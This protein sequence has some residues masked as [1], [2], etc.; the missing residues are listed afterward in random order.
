MRS[1]ST[2]RQAEYC[3]QC[4]WLPRSLPLILRAAPH[5]RHN[6]PPHKPP[7]G[8]NIKHLVYLFIYFGCTQFSF[9]GGS[10][11]KNLPAD[12]ENVGSIPWLGRSPGGGNGNPLQYSCQGNHMDCGA[13]WATVHGVTKTWI[14]LS[15]YTHVCAQSQLWHMNYQ[16]QHIRSSSL[17]RDQTQ[18]L[19][20]GSTESQPGD[21]QGNPTYA[22]ILII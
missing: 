1:A 4:T 7:S 22:I 18:A 16:L 3:S 13:W 12:A 15:D 10:V 17:I 9:P 2:V 8:K 20:I 11:V 14:Q 5:S 21:N 6:T 19:S